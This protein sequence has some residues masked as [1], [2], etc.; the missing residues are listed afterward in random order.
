MLVLGDSI[1]WGQGLSVQDKFWWRV[2]N[3]LQQKT[4]RE[5]KEKIEAHSGALIETTPGLQTLFTS[6]DGEVNLYTPTINEQI[7]DAKKYYRDTSVV[8]L[9][10]VN[11]CIND[12]DVRNLLDASSSLDRLTESIREKCGAN[13]HL[14]LRRVAT[15]FPAHT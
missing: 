8:D 15:E 2:K 5:V 10:I 7:D 4:G 13:M 9:I 11:G 3:W 6:D 12:V 14:L 1:T